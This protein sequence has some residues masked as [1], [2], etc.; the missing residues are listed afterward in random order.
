M[1]ANR[2]AAAALMLALATGAAQAQN[3]LGR[4]DFDACMQSFTA[5]Q[6]NRL[7]QS[8]QQLFQQYVA[9][10]QEWLQ[11][12]YAQ[13]R[14]G[15]GQMTF[16]Q[17]AY[18]GLMTANGTNMAGAAQAQ[19][20]WFQGSQ[21][22]NRTIQQGYADYNRGSAANSEA[23]SRTARNYSEGAIRG[24]TPYVDPESGQTRWLPYASQPGQPFNSGGQVYV[25]APNGA[26]YQQRGNGWVPMQPGR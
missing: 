17:F 14:A 11:R 1:Q 2:V 12:N 26:Y 5:M 9:T 23:T 7:A 25:Q 15:G 24:N 19:R 10:N 16:A 20:D 13:H 8:Q 6:Q 21:N 4:P 22:A 3:C 18:W